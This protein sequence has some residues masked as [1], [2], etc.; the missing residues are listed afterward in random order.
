MS[1]LRS[2][3]TAD[4]F[5]SQDATG[6][7]NDLS[8]P[9]LHNRLTIFK[10]PRDCAGASHAARFCSDNREAPQYKP[11]AF[12]KKIDTSLCSDKGEA[13]QGKLV[14]SVR[15]VVLAILLI[16]ATL[17]AAAQEGGTI[18]IIPP[19]NP[20][21]R[22]KPPRK[23]YTKVEGATDVKTTAKTGSLVALAAPNAKLF[24][25]MEGSQSEEDDREGQIEPGQ[26]HFIFTGL[27]PGRYRLSVELEDFEDTSGKNGVQFVTIKEDP[28]AV[29]VFNLRRRA[30]NVTINTNISA[31]EIT[32]SAKGEPARIATIRAN[33]VILPNLPA[34]KYDIEIRPTELGYQTLKHSIVVGEG[35]TAFKV[36][37]D[38]KLSAGVLAANWVTLNEWDAPQG[39]TVNTQKLLPKGRGVAL[40]RD[41]S[42]RYYA[43]F[44]MVCQVKMI[45]DTAASFVLRAKDKQNYY[46]IQITG[47][48]ADERYVVRGFVVQNGVERR[49]PNELLVTDQSISRDF[50]TVTIRCVE[51]RIKVDITT[52][53]GLDLNLGELQD[54]NSTFSVGAP[55][56]AI[57]GLEEV[58]VGFLHVKPLT[59]SAR[60]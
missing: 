19:S 10:T 2:A 29:V 38:R 15:A 57:R 58:E 3:Q 26:S 35:Q 30:Y 25:E 43:D 54:A 20:T 50:F 34:G 1:E 45:N 16:C 13:P 33:K 47:G 42:V 53:D 21:P 36:D 18:K 52:P 51:N 4:R 59:T 11:V 56:I 17:P 48:K 28:P 22:P 27:K 41:E 24:L 60:Q 6:L 9:L 23:K 46:L 8:R 5:D 12:A 37:I 39:W 44:E 31:G 7:P 40:P 32:Y 49:L 55:G 14:A